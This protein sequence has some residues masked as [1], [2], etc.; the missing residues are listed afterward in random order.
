[1]DIFDPTASLDTS[2]LDTCKHLN[3][4]LCWI[5]F[6]LMTGK[7]VRCTTAIVPCNL[8]ED[9]KYGLEDVLSMQM[10]N[11]LAEPG[12]VEI[13]QTVPVLSHEF[14]GDGQHND[15]HVAVVFVAHRTRLPAPRCHAGPN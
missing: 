13:Y 7:D 14:F 5:I 11:P 2:S 12:Q 6:N 9:D 1:M 10:P 4:H 8:T 15:Y 3:P